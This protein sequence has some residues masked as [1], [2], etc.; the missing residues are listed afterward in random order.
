MTVSRINLVTAWL[1]HCH[2][3]YLVLTSKQKGL[4]CKR[5]RNP[6]NRQLISQSTS[7]YCTT[8]FAQQE[9]ANAS[10]LALNEKPIPVI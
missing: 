2:W 7:L 8:L 1:T 6:V 3:R 10:G 9:L 4:H 5:V